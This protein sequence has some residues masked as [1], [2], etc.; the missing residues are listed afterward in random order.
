MLKTVAGY[1]EGNAF[2]INAESRGSD[3]L[4]SRSTIKPANIKLISKQV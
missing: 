1:F 3:D 2:E 4:A